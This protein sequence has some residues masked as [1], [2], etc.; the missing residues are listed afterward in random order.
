MAPAIK[1]K[2][3]RSTFAPFYRGRRVLV[4]GHTGF[5]GAW[6][7]E[8]LLELGAHVTGYALEPETEPSLFAQL[9]LATRMDH[10]I[11]DVRH[12]PALAQI[13]EEMR[14]EVVFHL[15]AQP[16][17]RLSY[18]QPADTY[19]TNIMG[20]V[21]LLDALRH[22]D[23]PCSV[24]MVTSDKCYENTGRVGGY[25]ENDRLGGHD[26]YSSSKACAELVVSSYRRSF[27]PPHMHPNVRVASARAGN[28]I[29]G[30]DWA[31]DRILPD[32]V[33][34][35][36]AKEPILVRNRRAIRPWQH[37]LEPVGGYL[38]LASRLHPEQDPAGERYP[39]LD[40]FNFGPR[41]EAQ[42]T[43]EAVVEEVLLHWSGSWADHTQE[44]APHE[45]AVL[46]LDVSKARQLLDWEPRWSFEAAITETV[47]WYRNA[48]QSSSE[49][50]IAMTRD[51][52]RR[53]MRVISKSAIAPHLRRKAAPKETLKP[54]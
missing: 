22:Y 46:T 51:Q 43:V 4:T 28:V 54:V 2:P 9:G 5:K 27:F 47:F 11:G 34:S 14:P 49:E 25:R 48:Q 17:V 21:R 10:R 39:L 36:I 40:T 7:C 19:D 23:H 41:P 8:W 29:G 20:T 16:L 24:V 50:I 18:D 12:G 35:L 30:G 44:N 42:R 1:R 3:A 13:I 53:Y 33:R 37:V 45:A 52:I 15:A 26:P 32:S 38:L 6:L 31:P